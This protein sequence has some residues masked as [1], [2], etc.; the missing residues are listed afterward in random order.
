MLGQ[1]DDEG[2]FLLHAAICS[3][4]YLTNST[5]FSFGRSL[6]RAT[7]KCFSAARHAVVPLLGIACSLPISARTASSV[8]SAAS[9]AGVAWGGS[10]AELFAGGAGPGGGSG[11]CGAARGGP[12]GGAPPP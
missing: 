9:G 12:P 5:Y 3:W 7:P 1:F 4:T 10:A 6:M 11:T 8:Q 2:V